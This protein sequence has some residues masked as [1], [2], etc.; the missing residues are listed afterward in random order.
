MIDVIVVTNKPANTPDLL[1]EI[2]ANT[3]EPYNGIWTCENASAS[4][5]RNKGLGLSSGDVVVMLD[6]DITGFYPGWLTQITAPLQ[7]DEIALVS[8]RLMATD[9]TP[10]AMMGS[11]IP[12]DDGIHDVSLSAYRG[13]RRVTTAAIAFRK[14][15]LR[16]CEDYIGSGYEDTD[17]MNEFNKTNPDKRLVINNACRLIHLNEEKNQGGAY[18]EH[19]HAVYLSRYPDDESV[20]VQ[21]DWTKRSR[22]L[23]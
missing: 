16:F 8:A 11:G 18:W 6:D 23:A 19:N 22:Q 4:I 7:D 20:K 17:F 2:E 21:Q 13:Y 5:N 12:F 15:D 9:G 14:T 10:G 3:P 1:S